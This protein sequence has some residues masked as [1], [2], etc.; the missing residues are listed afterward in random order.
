M[1]IFQFKDGSR[2]HPWSIN[3]LQISF[4]VYNLDSVKFQP[5]L[6]DVSLDIT[7]FYSLVITCVC[8]SVTA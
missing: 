5:Y 2:L 8:L 3:Q 7:F 1:K 6:P 4:M